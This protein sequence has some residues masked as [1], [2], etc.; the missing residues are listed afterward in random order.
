MLELEAPT[1]PAGEM[2]EPRPRRKSGMQRRKEKC[3]RLTQENEALREQV[4]MLKL[5]IL[6]IHRRLN[7]RRPITPDFGRYECPTTP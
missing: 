7:Q 3:L 1:M 2:P 4:E 5:A 6:E